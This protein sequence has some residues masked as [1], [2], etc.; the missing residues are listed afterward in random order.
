MGIV[1]WAESMPGS[2]YLS[3]AGSDATLNPY[4]PKHNPAIF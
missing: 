1:A 4:A 2:C 3:S